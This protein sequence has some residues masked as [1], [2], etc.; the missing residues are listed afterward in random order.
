M[1]IEPIESA[2]ERSAAGSAA[3]SSPPVVRIEDEFSRF[4]RH[5][6]DGQVRRAY[7]ILGASGPA[8]DVVAEAFIA[9]L[10]RWDSIDQPGP[11]LNRCVLNGCRDIHRLAPR[12]E[13]AAR[14]GESIGTI[15]GPERTVATIVDRIDETDEMAEQLLALPFR[16]RAAIVLRYY[17][18]YGESDIADYLNCRPGTVGSLIH[19]GLRTLRDTLAEG[20]QTTSNTTERPGGATR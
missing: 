6:H 8:H 7:L 12:E 10:R 20:V 5:E 11:Y 4:Y 3:P 18:G 17:G 9:V 16:Q 14:P 2:R 19:R 15:A 13:L 1:D